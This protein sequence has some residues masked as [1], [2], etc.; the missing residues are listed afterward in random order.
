LFQLFS[1]CTVVEEGSF[2][3]AAEK[4]Y[5]SQ[6]SVSQHISN[7][8]QYFNVSLFNRQKRKIRVTPEGRLLYDVAREILERLD[9]VKEQI[10]EIRS[11]SHGNISLGCSNYAGKYILPPI[12]SEYMETF[13]GVR[14]SIHTGTWSDLVSA[15]KRNEIEL[16]LAERELR[17]NFDTNVRFH[18]IGQDDLVFISSP[19]HPLA[20]ERFPAELLVENMVINYSYGSFLSTYFEDF[21][22]QHQLKTSRTI[23]V[24][25]FEI[26]K[27]LVIKGIGISLAS[28]LSIKHE[29]EEN[30]L[31]ILD[32]E[33]VKDFNFEI[34][35][36][37]H[38]TLGLSYAGWELLKLFQKIIPCMSS[39]RGIDPSGNPG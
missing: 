34:F 12:I 18:C 13:P 33:D 31:T 39:S 28:R 22:L 10:T 35:A 29:L 21:L 32:I 5:I 17:L 16:A 9:Q 37:Y 36:M 4:M 19:E 15:L 7:L 25:N 14:I 26:A 24:D 6:P 27:D 11:F 20:G 3:S 30:T 23:D 8:E 38:T 1:F 2:R